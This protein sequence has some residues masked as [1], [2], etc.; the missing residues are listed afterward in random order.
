MPIDE[1]YQ[2]AIINSVLDS[3]VTAAGG[4]FLMVLYYQGTELVG[5]GYERK[6]I[7]TIPDA[8]APNARG[9]CTA[10]LETDEPFEA[11]DDG[12][13]WTQVEIRSADG[14]DVIFPKIRYVGSIAAG[15]N[16]KV[17][18]VFGL[19]N[20]RPLDTQELI[21]E[22]LDNDVL[23][24]DNAVPAAGDIILTESIDII[25]T[26]GATKAGRQFVGQGFGEN[27]LEEHPNRGNITNFIFLGDKGDETP[28]INLRSSF[29]TI[30]NFSLAGCL[31]EQQGSTAKADIG[32][33][34]RQA[35]GGV[36]K[37]YSEP[38]FWYWLAIGLRLAATSLEG[39]CDEST[40]NKIFSYN[41]DIAVQCNS[42]NT[43]GHVFNELTLSSTPIAFDIN[44]GG[45]LTTRNGLIGDGETVWFKFND[46]GAYGSNSAKYYCENLKIDS[47]ADQSRLLEMETSSGYYSDLRFDI[48]QLPIVK[49]NRSLF[50]VSGK[51][52]T[53]VEGGVNLQYGMLSWNSPDAN[54]IPIFHLKDAIIYPYSGH[55]ATP[56]S[57]GELFPTAGMTNKCYVIAEDVWHWQGSPLRLVKLSDF[58]GELTGT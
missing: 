48:P 42:Q 6:S 44:G 19:P 5:N 39:N 43:M 24:G 2:Q 31:P 41:C 40:W 11:I 14:N 17:T 3:L 56:T 23:Y 8:S 57:A 30:G 16:R 12:L 55:P 13:Y 51:T 18:A 9:I 45:N 34:L 26:S 15:E 21:Q 10:S 4:S 52:K 54:T 25:G 7:S 47:Q 1:V 46:P 36:G 38:M 50:H 28:I 27:Y 33:D 29:C 49:W 22:G 58:E 35:D 53:V 32:I 37:I 20:T